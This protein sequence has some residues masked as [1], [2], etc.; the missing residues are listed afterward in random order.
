MWI[1]VAAA[2]VLVSACDIGGT[3]TTTPTLPPLTT[4]PAW[5]THLAE[6]TGVRPIWEIL[7]RPQCGLIQTT[8]G[9]ECHQSLASLIEAGSCPIGQTWSYI[10]GACQPTVDL[11]DIDIGTAFDAAAEAL[12]SSQ[13]ALERLLQRTD[14]DS[15]EVDAAHNRWL[16][17]RSNPALSF[18]ED[19]VRLR[20]QSIQ[21]VVI[22]IDAAD[23]TAARALRNGY[24]GLRG[25]FN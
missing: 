4:L 2:A 1:V 12:E 10:A 22:V 3:E 16:R 9:S 5:Y 14:A 13:S 17:A 15:S 8:E 7:E 20:N 19:G 6:D 21:R 23:T 18:T 11:S 25:R 24:R